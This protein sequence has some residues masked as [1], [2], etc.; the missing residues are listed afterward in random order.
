MGDVVWIGNWGDEERTGELFEFFVEPVRSLGLKA[1]AC[2]VRY[3]EAGLE[4]LARSG[5]QYGGWVPNY[6]APA[7]FA[8][9]R[10]TV[11]IPRRPYVRA[12]PGIPTIRPFEA[13]ACGI[14]LVCSPWEDAEGLF[15]PGRDYLTAR[16][17]KEMKRHLE[18]VIRDDDTAR[19]LASH[20]LQTI[21]SRHTCGHR[22]DEL[23]AIYDSLR[24]VG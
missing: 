13:L 5:I 20:G 19:E 2:G 11:H 8:R 4:A 21:L 10:A 3:P 15:T 7:I 12:L 16:D 22:V 14:P 24:T 23:L 9:F 17:G 1:L 6:E 18:A